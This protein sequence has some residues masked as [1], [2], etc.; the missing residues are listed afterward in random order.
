MD[1]KGIR[2]V[3]TVA[4]IIIVSLLLIKLLN[5][6]YPVSI[7]STS[8]SSELAVVGEGKVDVIPDRAYVDVGITVDNATSVSAAQKSINTINNEIV[9]QLKTIGIQKGDIK[10]SNYSIYPNYIYEGSQNVLDG[11]NGNVTISVTVKDTN[12]V[13]KVIEQ[14]TAAGANQVQNTRFVVNDPAKYREEA[15]AKAIQ[16]A[17]E[18]AQKLASSLGITLGKVVNIVESSPGGGVI[19]MMFEGKAMNGG[20][21]GG[22]P[23][24]QAGSETITSVVTLYFEKR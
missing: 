4:A 19:P 1:E 13:G 7:T 8:R 10:T 11:Y 22:A 18:Q 9:K 20:G 23:D 16:N 12:N 21:G 14:A 15:R 3:V 17:K 24:M 2:T 5:I 6:S